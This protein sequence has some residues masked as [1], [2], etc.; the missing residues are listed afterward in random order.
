M[1]D[2]RWVDDRLASLEPSADW[3]PDSRT[4]FARLR[5]RE[6]VASS[7][8]AVGVALVRSRGR[9]FGAGVVSA[10]PACANPLGC[11]QQSAR[12]SRAGASGFQGGAGKA[13]SFNGQG[14]P[15]AR[16]TCEV[17]YGLSVPALRHVLSQYPAAT[18]GGIT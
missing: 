5:R 14:S 3:K 7:L 4:A 6:R 18:G 9:L 1:D 2:K 15:N 11:S 16:V 13:A 8:V 10:P 17:V 12:P